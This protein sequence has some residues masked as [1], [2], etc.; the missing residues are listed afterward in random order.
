VLSS[1]QGKFVYVAN[2][3]NIVTIKPIVAGNWVGKDWVILSGLETGDKVIVDNIIKLRPG[4]PVSPHP[5]SDP[6]ASPALKT[7]ESAGSK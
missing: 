3:K 5:L 1:D 2:D 4:A 7:N 6:S